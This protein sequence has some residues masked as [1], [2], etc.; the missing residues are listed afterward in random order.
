MIKRIK[1]WAQFIPD[2]ERIAITVMGA[3]YTIFPAKD[4]A[5]AFNKLARTKHPII[6]VEISYSIK[7]K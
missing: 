7:K 3:L 1:A 2:E 6:E 4:V 5:M